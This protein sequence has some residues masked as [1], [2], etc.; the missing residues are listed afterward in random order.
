MKNRTRR[1][2]GSATERGLPM[3]QAME[4]EIAQPQGIAHAAQAQGVIYSSVQYR[5]VTWF[6]GTNVHSF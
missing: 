3:A 2:V 5:H 4:T 6:F 1:I